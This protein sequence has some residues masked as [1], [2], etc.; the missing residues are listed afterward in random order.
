MSRV[1]IIDA[2][3][4]EGAQAP[5]VRFS[6]QQ[7][8]TIAESLVACGVDAIEVGHPAAGELEAARV[9][10]I[11]AAGMGCAVLAHARAIPADVE[12]VARCGADWVGVFL[13]VNP[14]TR[15]V[16]IGG[17]TS[18]EALLDRIG[19]A[20]SRAR[21]LGLR[22]R[23]TVE[24]ASRTDLD[25]LRRAC[26]YALDAG[27]DR[28]CFAD[29]VGVLEPSETAAAVRALREAFPK[30]PLEVHLHD[31]RGLA[32]ANA[33]A[34][35]DAGAEWVATSVNG[36]GE[37]CGIVDT[38][39][40][41]ANLHYRGTRSLPPPG[42]IPRLS[43]LVAAASASPPS[44]RAPVVGANAF[45]HTAKLHVRAVAIDERSYT[46]MAPALLG[47]STRVILPKVVDD[48]SPGA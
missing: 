8:A 9:R 17:E 43:D 15:R 16:R 3:L 27:A 10:A 24:D 33:L 1:S 19:A 11:V 18:I 12:A 46:W 2:T 45:T 48:P 14:M 38:S 40:L 26:A 44:P 21:A 35:L 6:A 41:L 42:A 31:D 25:D 4:R 36:L 37:R 5:G 23:Y 22:V 32:L 34:A 13:G 29:S 28:I 7:S 20:V 47:R 30:C 39:A